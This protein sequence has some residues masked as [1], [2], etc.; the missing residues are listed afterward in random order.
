MPPSMTATNWLYDFKSRVEQLHAL[1]EGSDYG[2]S[3]IRFGGLLAP[4]AF[5]IATQQS[6]AQLNAWSLEESELKFVFDPSAEETQK[7]V[8]EQQGYVVHGL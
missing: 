7:A 6:A 1:H 4:E 8:E 2:R 5:L 3:G